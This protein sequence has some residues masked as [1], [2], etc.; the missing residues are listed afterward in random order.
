[1]KIYVVTIEDE[2][3]TRLS[4][5]L[6][7]NFFEQGNLP[8]TKLGIKGGELSAKEYFEKAVK[9]RV[10]PLT[11]GRVRLYFVTLESFRAIFN[12]RR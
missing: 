7:Q 11:P 8:I 6:G 3:S 12:Y 1:M 5:F 2:K 9:G 10:K 4:N